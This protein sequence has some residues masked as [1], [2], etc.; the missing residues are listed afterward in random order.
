MEDQT[1]FEL[2]SAIQRWR[3]EL[4]KSPA[5]HRESLDELEV[6]LRDSIANLQSQRFS[7]K[8]SF[9]VSIQRIGIAENL[10]MEF[11]KVNRNP[12]N[13][14][15]CS[16]QSSIFRKNMNCKARIAT[17]LTIAFIAWLSSPRAITQ[18]IVFVILLTVAFGALSLA[19]KLRAV[20]C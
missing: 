10:E 13:A 2:N 9:L 7:A 11:A 8:D 18:M 14:L 20:K 16:K 5:F 17:I 1:S 19:K 4:A 15:G 3:E 6:H 12:T